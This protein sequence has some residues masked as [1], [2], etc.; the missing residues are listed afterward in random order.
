M[1]GHTKDKACLV[2]TREAD[3]LWRDY[4]VGFLGLEHAVLRQIA[5]M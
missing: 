2:C 3:L 4:L 1:T 5:S